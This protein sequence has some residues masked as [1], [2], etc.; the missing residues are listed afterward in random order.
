MLAFFKQWF[1]SK[2]PDP[3]PITPKDTITRFIGDIKTYQEKD[4]NLAKSKSIRIDVYTRSLEELGK[5][6]R[7]SSVF[8]SKH[9]YIPDKWKMTERKLRTSTLEDFISED[10]RTILH[11]IDWLVSQAYYITKIMDALSTMDEAEYDYYQ[12][13]C[14]FIIED[15]A[16]LITG[17]D[18]IVR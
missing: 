13:Q 18:K 6:L 7:Q 4:L 9:E 12:R 14:N 15:L 17:V 11:P 3:I 2:E 8:I 1:K 5:L 10:L 16:S